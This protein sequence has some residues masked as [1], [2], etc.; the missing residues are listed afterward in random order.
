MA[1]VAAMQWL[2]PAQAKW[3]R[4]GAG[5]APARPA[6]VNAREGSAQDRAGAA[7]GVRRRLARR[8][9]LERAWKLDEHAKLKGA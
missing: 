2:R 6:G 8:H 1:A 4:C 7:R 5:R 9:D 3:W